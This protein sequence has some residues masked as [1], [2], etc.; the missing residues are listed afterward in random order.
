MKVARAGLQLNSAVGSSSIL[1]NSIRNSS[2]IEAYSK[3]ETL[4]ITNPH[5]YVFHVELNRPQKR[6]SMTPQLFDEI[7]S[8]FEQLAHDSNCRSIVLTGA[9]KSFCAGID[10]STLVEIGTK[11]QDLETGR[12]AFAMKPYIEKWQ[13]SMSAPEI[14]HK[15]V[16]ALVHGHCVGGGINLVASCDIRYACD[17][18]LFSVREVDVGLAADIGALQRMPREI[19]ND[20]LLRELVYTARNF[21]P[22]EAKTLGFISRVFP[23]RD[24]MITA[25][26]EL[27]KVIASKSPIAVQ[28]SKI[29]LIFSRDHTV[30]DGL[31]H[32]VAWNIGMLQSEDTVKAAMSQMTKEPATFAKL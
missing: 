15:P 7:T 14:C 12:R 2:T 28:G 8:C 32:M 23:D 21:N 26:L 18:A 20:S 30:E 11:G 29:H 5:E 13:R 9:G 10:L 3:F 31:K 1:A 4:K 17:D 16:I 19:G 27:A 22:E 24:S 25:G 6:N